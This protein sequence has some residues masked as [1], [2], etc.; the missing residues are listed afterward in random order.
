MKRLIIVG[1][2]LV[3]L[4]GVVITVSGDCQTCPY[5][6]LAG[7]VVERR[8]SGPTQITTYA[9]PNGHTWQCHY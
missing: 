5:C 8:G 4:F 7:Y 9:C 3:I 2:I 1:L 6:G